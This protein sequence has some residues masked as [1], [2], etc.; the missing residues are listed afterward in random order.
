MSQP[1]VNGE[2]VS[3]GDCAEYWTPIASLEAARM[4][5]GVFAAVTEQTKASVDA[6]PDE[7]RERVIANATRQMLLTL[8]SRRG[9]T[10]QLLDLTT[11]PALPNKTT[12]QLENKG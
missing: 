6:L 2:P 1:G 10:D 11:A 8:T 4:T 5:R 7:A 12:P 9:D 3:K